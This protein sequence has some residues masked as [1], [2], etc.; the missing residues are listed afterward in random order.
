MKRFTFILSLVFLFFS[1]STSIKT[2]A[3]SPGIDYNDPFYKKVIN[4]NARIVTTLKEV[5]N[6]E[7]MIEAITVGYMNLGSINVSLYYD[8]DV[9]VPI[10]G[11][12]GLEITTNQG[13][14]AM[15][16]IVTISPKVK[17]PSDWLAST[18]GVLYP[19]VNPPW[20]AC[21]TSG[22][23]EVSDTKVYP[24]CI[25]PIYKFYF[26]IKPGQT[27]SN[28]TFRYYNKSTIPAS[29]NEFEFGTYVRM[30]SPS[31]GGNINI[32]AEMFSMRVP[33][34]IK[35]INNP[36]VNG[37]NV[38]LNGHAEVMSP[39]I[40]KKPTVIGTPNISGLDWDTIVSTGFIY[41]KS[42]LT[43]LQIEEYTRA[44]TV[45]GTQ[46]SDPQNTNDP[47]DPPP[48][49]H[50]FHFLPVLDFFKTNNPNGS[51]SLNGHTFYFQSTPNPNTSNYNLNYTE[52]ITGLDPN[53]DYY[54]YAI[55]MYRFQTSSP[56]PIIGEKIHFKTECE[57]PIAPF[58]TS[59]FYKCA[60]N[61]TITLASIP[62]QGTNAK[63]YNELGN[64]IPSTTLLVNNA[65]YYVVELIGGCESEKS[66]VK[67]VPVDELPPPELAEEYS[68][69]SPKTLGEISMPVDTKVLWYDEEEG[70]TLLPSTT[71]VEDGKIYW[72]SRVSTN[73]GCESSRRT[74][75]KI[76]IASTVPGPVLESPQDFCE[77]AMI[78]S[79]TA[80]P[81]KWDDLLWFK[82]P[83]ATQ[84]ITDP[85][86]LLEPGF[87]YAKLNINSTCTPVLTEVEIIFDLN[88]EEFIELP[89]V[90]C[91]E[92]K[93]E[94]IP[95]PGWAIKWFADE[96]METPLDP[97]VPRPTGT[98]YVASSHVD[99]LAK[100]YKVD[101]TVY[102]VVPDPVPIDDDFINRCDGQQFCLSD[103]LNLI[104]QQPGFTYVVYTDA[105]CTTKFSNV[106]PSK[107]TT[108]TYPTNRTF[109]VRAFVTGTD[110][111]SEIATAL[112]LHVIVNPLP[113]AP[114][115]KNNA[116][117]NICEGLSITQQFLE[118]LINIPANISIE[119]YT[120]S[121][122][123]VPFSTVNNVVYPGT[124]TFYAI[125][126]NNL[127]GC[128]SPVSTALQVVIT[129]IEAPPMPIVE[130][131]N[132]GVLCV[133]ASVMLY[134]T[135]ADDYTSPSYQWYLEND[136]IPGENNTY[137][138]TLVEGDYYLEVTEGGCSSKSAKISVTDS[139]DPFD[140]PL[141]VIAATNDGSLCD[142]G[143][144]N[145]FL[146]ID[147][148]DDY[149]DVAD[150][151]Y[152]WYKDGLP[153]SNTDNPYYV[154]TEAGDYHVEVIIDGC[155]GVSEFPYTVAE[156]TDPFDYPEP[157]VKVS[158]G[159]V[160]CEGSS[161]RLW[162]N[163]VEDYPGATYQW[164]RD[165]VKLTGATDDEY[166]AS[167]PGF[168]RIEIIID[169]CSMVSTGIDIISV[170]GSDYPNPH[171]T[172]TNDGVL[173]D[174]DDVTVMLYVDNADSYEDIT[175]TYQWY[176]NNTEVG[177]D[178]PYYITDV[179]GTYYVEA[180][181]GDCALLSNT[182]TVSESSSTFD[183]PTPDIQVTNGGVICDEANVM[184][185]VDN[186]DV[187]PS[188]TTYQW[189]KDG[190]PIAGATDSYW[191]VDFDT[192]GA[193]VYHVEV[194][195]DDCSNVSV[196]ITVTEPGDEGFD[197]PTPN[198]AASNDGV[199]CDGDEGDV[200]VMLYLT[201]AD[202]FEGL[203]YQ[204]YF[205]G[206]PLPD[207]QNLPYHLTNVAGMYHVEVIDA[208][209]SMVSNGK[210]VT[211]PTTGT[212]DYPRPEIG[213]TN[214]GSICVDANVMLYINN[215]DEYLPLTDFTFQWY[216][217]GN[218]INDA[219]L[220]YYIVEY[221]SGGEGVYHVEVSDG[222]CSSVSAGATVTEDSGNEYPYT[223][224]IAS[225]NG[226]TIC[227][228]A[229]VMLYL[230]DIDDYA[231]VT[232]QWYG[233]GSPIA[234]ATSSYYIV[235]AGDDPIYSI[236][237]LEVIDGDCSMVSN[238]ISVELGTGEFE[239]NAPNIAAT[240]DGYLCDGNTED[241]Y[242]MLYVTNPEDFDGL[243]YQWYKDGN[244]ITGAT[245]SY[246]LTN[247]EGMYHVE[248]LDGGC[249]MVSNGMEV[250]PREE[251]T[252]D[253]PR[254]LVEVTNDGVICDGANVMLYVS[255]SEEFEGL[256]YQWYKDG[257]LQVGA[258]HPYLVVSEPGIYHVEVIDGDCSS[259]SEGTEVEPGTGDPFDYP[260]PVIA[261]TN[262]G[263]LCEDANVMLYI[264]NLDQYPA[265]VTYQWYKDGLPQP[266]TNNSFYIVTD[267]GD[268]HVEVIIDGCSV[269]SEDAYTVTPNTGETFD[270]VTPIIEVTN[271]G[272]LCQGEGA[273]IMLMITNLDDYVGLG[274]EWY[275]D[276]I[277][278]DVQTH[279]IVATEPGT[280]YVEIVGDE[281]SKVF[282]ASTVSE[283]GNEFEAPQPIIAATN[284]ATLCDEAN[285]ML[286]ITNVDDYTD[287]E[288]TYQ[289]YRNGEQV[290]ENLPYYV[291]D[292][293]G[294]YY[295]EVII[296]EC[297]AASDAMNVVTTTSTFTPDQP[298]IAAT[299]N[300]MLCEDKTVMLSIENITEFEDIPGV[301]YQ[302]YFEGY[303]IS[304][305]N[306]TEYEA[307]EPGVYHVEV[308]ID[309]CSMVSEEFNV[310][311]KPTCGVIL[312]GTVYPF[313]NHIDPPDPVFDA[314]FPIRASL[315]AM[316]NPDV[317]DLI[318]ELLTVD[319]IYPPVFAELYDGLTHVPNT[320][321]YP[322]TLGW[323]NNYGYPIDFTDIGAL[324]EPTLK[325][326][327]VEEGFAPQT[328]N[329]MTIGL[330]QFF[331]ILPG[332][333]LLELYREGYMVRWA[334]I[335]VTDEPVQYIEHR[336]LIPGDV[337]AVAGDLF[338]DQQIDAQDGNK[339]RTLFDSVYGESEY[340][341]PQYD[342][343]ASGDVNAN[344]YNLIRKYYGFYFFHYEDTR[345]WLK[346]YPGWEFLDY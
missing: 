306:G 229:N 20:V 241:I 104:D 322:G 51:I 82:D 247:E 8:P 93:L 140:Y 312:I 197:Y 90:A 183:Y 40:A 120:N 245:L 75:V 9:V 310:G 342:S 277:W 189:Y 202:E 58:V 300:G 155:S 109:Y 17:V 263:E 99:C 123:T 320:P 26:R 231:G 175:V 242:V 169:D 125:A 106:Y 256:S 251:E 177:S 286:Y 131:T 186:E 211:I 167:E 107:C 150:V 117:K 80:Q 143:Y 88:L 194:I 171:I 240:N 340:F 291:T 311:S 293:D 209:C 121:G 110:C 77:G 31:S 179:A 199:L 339:L 50:P 156:S 132:A 137:Y 45:N 206:A 281:C 162:L 72:A 168:Y 225:T 113:A 180:K 96:T 296:G 161:V 345:E 284:N 122:C 268:Y 67:V 1:L 243:A 267:P 287:F 127:T 81:Y 319:P 65:T 235:S 144:A 215:I 158:N 203:D 116:N 258:T 174:G 166:F 222:D 234:G 84:P 157:D 278:L 6:N 73:G 151:H 154:A 254:P 188:G 112:E 152:Q 221:G 64:H 105:L 12:G 266:A 164:F 334:K 218:P 52:T 253:Y 176:F 108:V 228:D 69:C 248:V 330:Y 257:V 170:G 138:V 324:H 3:Q 193:G 114:V 313:V 341:D 275:R 232:Y 294:Y 326:G 21:R 226:G 297:S 190:Y 23:W 38:T 76:T 276:G 4:S 28:Q 95:I 238:G 13:T 255:N 331:D 101:L 181:I 250:Q 54:A 198:L 130:A 244:P 160:L 301:Q 55:A 217:N 220:P 78:Y 214:D 48:G 148:Y 328:I 172:A 134:L 259:V 223:P 285:V 163:N 295:V 46:Y 44:L 43:S 191:I 11:P 265:G 208:D 66:A 216:F 204:W 309:D 24:G 147:N 124:Y 274:F 237:H 236:Y 83:A 42:N 332:E 74:P 115:F 343:N 314:L 273:T 338:S 145:I 307:T 98:Y 103:L 97:K 22:S 329:D 35:T 41:T 57:K 56:Y 318:I 14:A 233:D 201:N 91:E 192:D 149:A 184:L 37:T 87:Y 264:A 302:W 205:N 269:V 7:V 185:Y 53:T 153:L 178:L 133:D 283:G 182:I 260:L 5:E 308:I 335:T 290:G 195:I 47:L 102:D 305:A 212:F 129:V 289:W 292:V 344:D 224:E 262:D 333:Y 141:P 227:I 315:K 126:K 111:G 85:A 63:W 272:D 61:N 327:F 165:A 288:V 29:Y 321:D 317:E 2:S 298:I 139:E 32:N 146:Y 213:V 207:S 49:L 280:Y 210:E 27:L 337:V 142:G 100:H 59:V 92:R 86:T 173:C 271:N 71:T 230:L 62:V 249:S 33:A 10:W 128:K 15:R 68:F 304:L 79:I 119:F 39:H 200:Y 94:D 196:G 18:T 219:N 60:T 270:P 336:E 89:V 36:V 34:K 19:T 252:F 325:D 159:G 346:E 282:E 187:Y 316:P 303:P 136:P 323:F 239:H 118:N 30:W 279:Y 70:G 16:T 246:Y 299:N 135:N 25:Q 261:A